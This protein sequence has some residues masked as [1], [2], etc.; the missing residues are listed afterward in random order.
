MNT[1]QEKKYL[2]SFRRYYPVQV[3]RVDGY[4]HL[5]AI[6]PLACNIKLSINAHNYKH[7]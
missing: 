7:L 5:S 6:A 4:I 2:A 1:C 3:L